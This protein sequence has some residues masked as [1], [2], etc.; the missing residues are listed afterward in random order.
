[1]TSFPLDASQ[2]RQQQ[3]QQ[4][5]QHTPPSIASGNAKQA[6]DSSKHDSWHNN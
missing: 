3:Q 4:Q 2:A 5:Q 6:P 1:M